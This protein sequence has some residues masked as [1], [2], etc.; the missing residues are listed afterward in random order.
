M[1]DVI[2]LEELPQYF[3]D[4]SEDWN[5]MS[6]E[7]CLQDEMPII[8]QLHAGFFRDETGPDGMAWRK[9]SPVTQKRVGAE[10]PDQILVDAGELKA[11]LTE[12][13]GPNGIREVQQLSDGWTLIF[14]TYDEKSAFHDDESHGYYPPIGSGIVP[15]RPHVGLTD[16]YLDQAV[17]RVA[18]FALLGMIDP[19][20]TVSFA[21]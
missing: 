16:E 11:S 1:P 18:D 5:R 6:Y 19:S 12:L 9:L 13:N 21:A 10:G 4:I 17:E 15:Y 2:K 14:G 8:A 20:L 3:A 7:K